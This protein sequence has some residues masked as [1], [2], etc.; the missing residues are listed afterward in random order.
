M[1][2]IQVL[3]SHVADLIAAGE[4][5]ERPASVVKELVENAIDAG[6]GAV[7]VEIAHGGMTFL[8]VTDNGCGIPASELKTA[9]LRHATSKLRTEYDL[10]AI[11]TLGFRGEALA[12][13]SSVSRMEVLTR[14]AGSDFGVSLK[15]QKDRPVLDI[16]TEKFPLSASIGVVALCWAICLGIPL[17]CLAAYNRGKWIDSLLRVICTLGVSMP[18]FVVATFLLML[19]CNDG[20]PFK[21]LGI[22]VIFN[23]TE[24][25][26]LAYLMPCLALGLYP[27]CYIA[28]LTRSSMLDALGQDY[29]KTAR[30]KGLMTPKIIFKHALRNA[31]IPVITYL[32]PLTAFTLVGGFVVET[33][34]TIPGLGRYL[35]QS[36]QN[37]DYFIIMG[38]TIFLA[39]LVV[40]M[41]LVVDILYRVVDPR[42]DLTKGE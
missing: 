24:D 20:G 18:G 38:T 42:I 27:M 16:I 40:I 31:V 1:P 36:V 8:R 9:F 32:G 22:N 39:T 35:V 5:V 30:A 34:Y 2:H 29:I 6:A 11:G 21:F 10:E 28:R 41:N 26:W 13:I 14:T 23:P 7:T 37:R 25:G 3:D 17:G 4:V 19:F 12:A 15:M 33:V